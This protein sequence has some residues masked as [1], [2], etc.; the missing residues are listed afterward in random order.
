VTPLRGNWRRGSPGSALAS[1]MKRRE[2]RM[3]DFHVA[4]TPDAG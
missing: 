3:Y 2:P 1:V 4:R